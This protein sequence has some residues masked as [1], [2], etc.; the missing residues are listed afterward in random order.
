MRNTKK[1]RA[2][3]GFGSTGTDT[4]RM[5]EYSDLDFLAV[6]K[7]GH[8]QAL[9]ENLNW[10]SSAAPIRYCFVD[11]HGAYR[12]F[13]HDGIY[14]E[15]GVCEENEVDEIPHSEGRIIWCEEDF[16]KNVR[17]PSRECEYD[18][19]E[20]DSNV[21]EILT[22]LYVGLCRYARG[23]KLAAN[24][25]IQRYA[26]DYLLECSCF[27]SK[28]TPFYKDIFSMDRRYEMRF[29]ELVPFLSSMIQ[30]YEKCPEAALAIL[31]CTE[32][33]FQVDPFVRAQIIDLAAKCVRSKN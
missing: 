13:F 32:T 18:I 4:E 16:D 11:K 10:L 20:P 7:K 2:L 33:H 1:A 26:L 19:N 28:E 3:I 6:A 9:S 21:A 24:R 12:V 31:Q 29:P 22:N 17:L 23:E 25:Y 27:M 15:F 5:D 14:C 30:G 8:K